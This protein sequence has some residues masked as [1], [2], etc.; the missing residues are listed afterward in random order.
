M[1]GPPGVL[2]WFG[3]EQLTAAAS[4]AAPVVAAGLDAV[5]VGSPVDDVLFDGFPVEIL[6]ECFSGQGGEFFVGG[7]AEAYELVDGEFAD[8]GA[9]FEREELGEAQ[10]LFEADDAVLGVEGGA[11][12]EAGHHEEDD[13]HDDPPDVEPGV[14]RP[15][16][17]GAVDGDDEVQKEH[18][19]DKEME[20]RVP[21]EVVFIALRGG[22]NSPFWRCGVAEPGGT[23]KCTR[24][25]CWCG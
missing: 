25:S 20:G 15:V 18:G 9:V 22:H 10:A 12:A 4:A 2:W 1:N 16:M 7:E 8:S 21:A 24:S 6:A 11:A 14:V 23:E 3:G 19:Q 17:N 13:G 5:V